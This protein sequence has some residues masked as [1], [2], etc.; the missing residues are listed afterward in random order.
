MV[1]GHSYSDSSLL[2]MNKFRI[3]FLKMRVNDSNSLPEHLLSKE[4]LQ[5]RWSWKRL[6]ASALC[7]HSNHSPPSVSAH[8]QLL[9]RHGPPPPLLAPTQLIQCRTSGRAPVTQY[10][11]MT[12]YLGLMYVTT[13]AAPSTQTQQHIHRAF[14]QPFSKWP[15]LAGSPGWPYSFL[16]PAVPEKKLWG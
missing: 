11:R 14:Q 10:N 13:V 1:S 15:G 6:A 3:I 16:S 5:T 4:N 12:K 2:K 7:C 9:P 8:C